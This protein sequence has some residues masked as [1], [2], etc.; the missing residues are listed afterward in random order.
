M[1]PAVT[2]PWFRGNGERKPPNVRK[3]DTLEEDKAD[4]SF[5]GIPIKH[6]F[7]LEPAT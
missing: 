7:P 2:A 5:P 3:F 1:L 4:I 6:G